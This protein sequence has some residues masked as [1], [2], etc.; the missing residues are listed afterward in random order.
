MKNYTSLL[1]GACL[2]F[3]T[4]TVS[5]EKQDMEQHGSH[6]HGVARL[7]VA[8]TDGGLEI[9]LESPAANLFGFEHKAGT[10]EEHHA[11]H[12]AV[13]QLEA[14]AKLFSMN[15]SAGCSFDNA[16]V[17]SNI[18]AT[19]NE[20][21]HGD[22]D[23]DDHKGEKHDGH[24]DESHDDHKDEKHDDHK[25]EAHDDHKDEKHDDHAGHDNEEEGSHSDVDV[26]WTFTCEKPT[27][28]T[29]VSTKLFSAFPKGFEEVA[30]EWIT[31]SSAGKTELKEDG[32]ITLKQ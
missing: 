7:T 17:E 30:V 32:T 31:P 28:I 3:S 18:A 12:E 25:D 6:E 8:T 23:H 5:A 21:K 22:E 16:K 27:E 9:A 14:G 15:E 10:E 2:L 13:E 26:M 19:H 4:H 1:A 11:V 24:K 29:S 20:E